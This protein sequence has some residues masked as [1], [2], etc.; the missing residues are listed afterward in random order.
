[1][2]P[3]WEKGSIITK[4]KTVILLFLGY[5]INW[6]LGSV[7]FTN[8]GRAL[9][10]RQSRPDFFALGRA[11]CRRES[12]PLRPLVV[13]CLSVHAVTFSAGGAPWV[14]LMIVQ[15]LDM[16]L[17]LLISSLDCV[18]GA[19]SLVL[20]LLAFPFALFGSLGTLV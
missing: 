6:K 19:I 18:I 17:L 9:R 4:N 11:P 3:I 16:G 8:D 5:R 7:S 15:R 1:M 20:G 10:S 13:S 12:N 2:V 14:T